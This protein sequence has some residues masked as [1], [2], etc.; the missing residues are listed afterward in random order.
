MHHAV[1]TIITNLCSTIK[2]ESERTPIPFRTY[3]GYVAETPARQLR[4]IFQ[5]FYDMIHTLV[6]EGYDECPGDPESVNFVL[7]NCSRLFVNGSDHP[8]FADRIFANRFINTIRSLIHCVPQNRM[9]IFRGPHG[10]GKSTFLNNLLLK[11]EQFTRSE[12]GAIHETIWRLDRKRLGDFSEHDAQLI[13]TRLIRFS[14]NGTSHHPGRALAPHH[15]PSTQLSCNEYL[16]IPCPSHDNPILLI[17][18]AHRRQFLRELISDEPFKQRLFSEKS[19][20]WL[21]RANACTICTSLYQALVDILGSPA[22]AFDML[23]SRRYQFS[24]GLGEGISVYNPA[25]REPRTK[26]LSNQLLQNQLNSLLRDSNRVKYV[27]SRYAKTNNGV[28]ALMDIKGH[29]KERFANLH[30]IISEGIHKVDDIEE[31]VSSLFLALLNPEDGEELETESF[32]DRITPIKIGYILDHNTEI[33]IYRTVFG[34]HIEADFLPRVL[35]NFSR[36][37]ISSR[38]RP[39]SEGLREWIDNPEKYRPYCDRNLHLL[40]MD[41]YAGA[42]PLWLKEEDRKTFTSRRRR[43]IIAE[44]EFEGEWG[45]SG[46]DSIAIF[47]EFYSTYAAS[48]KLISMDMVYNFFTKQRHDLCDLLPEGFLRAIVRFYNYSVLQEVKEALYYYNEGHIARDIKNYLFAI[49]FDPGQIQRCVYTGDQI[50]ICEDFLEA[51]ESRFFSSPVPPAQRL[52]FRT[53]IQHQYAS[54]TLTQEMLLHGKPLEDTEVYQFLYERYVHNLKEKV[55]EPFLRNDNFRRAIKEYETPAFKT[56][57]Q[58]IR[59]EVTFLMRN[60]TTKY[61]YTPQGAK[62]VCM[63]VV[64]NNL[65]RTFA[66]R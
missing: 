30:G 55:M 2:A 35:Q 3:L 46:R 27:F 7:F 49:N 56:F 6:G 37:I 14:D 10:S 53:E 64:D 31:N 65:A 16:E 39:S 44:S 54:R 9:F 1:D 19:Y 4:T 61:K 28:Y 34:D 50:D 63:Y 5:L 40:K 42:L 22:A 52:I 62:E 38:L 25:D 36:I 21:F 15:S 32:S 8:F 41:I 45:F 47:N 18:K 20:E 29:N 60:L 33:K 26:V 12:E 11:F 24:R 59:E 13:L 57:D 23:Y 58:R 43:H 66:E 51:I 48:G 17:P